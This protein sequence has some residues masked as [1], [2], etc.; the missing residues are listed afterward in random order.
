M[1]EIVQPASENAGFAIWIYNPFLNANYTPQTTDECSHV[2]Q[3]SMCYMP[4]LNSMHL[5]KLSDN[6]TVVGLGYN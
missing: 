4:A 6:M 1:F 5:S 3:R 2:S